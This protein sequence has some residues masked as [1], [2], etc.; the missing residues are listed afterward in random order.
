MILGKRIIGES[1][2]DIF[3]IDVVKL[4]FTWYGYL[5]QYAKVLNLLVEVGIKER[6]CLRQQFMP[7]LFI[8][9]H[10]IELTIKYELKKRGLSFEDIHNVRELS[11][12]LGNELPSDFY[13]EFSK[14]RID[15]DGDCF[16]YI[17]TVDGKHHFNR[18]EVIEAL[19][20]LEYYSK[21]Y[22]NKGKIDVIPIYN[23]DGNNKK[24]RD[25]FLFR[26]IDCEYLGVMRTQYDTAITTL[27]K[28]MVEN[29]CSVEEIFMPL[30]FMLRHSVE[31]GLKDN[32]KV[33]N[34]NKGR[35]HKLRTLFNTLSKKVITNCLCRMPDSYIQLKQETEQYKERIEE[36]SDSI[37]ILD[38][39][40]KNFRFPCD[41]TISF[42]TDTLIK[43]YDLYSLSD[44]FLT[45]GTNVLAE[46][47][48]LDEITNIYIDELD[49]P[50]M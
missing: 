43:V 13:Y 5:G 27:L 42:S 37:S 24:Q 15:N 28:A 44:T 3:K 18:N 11:L 32:L 30:M 41:G 47:G 10:V 17:E 31:L 48:F 38:N 33:A 25:N 9:R 34:L 39:H 1:N 4:D 12:P 29:K 36:L 19:P 7:F 6:A 8:F 40:A 49:L 14:L 21:W 45:F 46:Y 35:E 26:I 2:K 23:V 50:Q 22:N 20:I 16:R